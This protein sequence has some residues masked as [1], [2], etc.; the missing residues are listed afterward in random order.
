MGLGHYGVYLMTLIG[1]ALV[2]LLNGTPSSITMWTDEAAC[3]TYITFTDKKPENKCIPVYELD[4][5]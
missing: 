1:W 5:K 3:L 4:K 2:A